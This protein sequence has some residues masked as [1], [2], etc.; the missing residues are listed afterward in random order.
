MG[1]WPRSWSR[2]GNRN[3]THYSLCFLRGHRLDVIITRVE[4][5]V[6]HLFHCKGGQGRVTRC[7]VLRGAFQGTWLVFPNG[8]LSA[9]L[10]LGFKA[11]ISVLSSG[12]F[13]SPITCSGSTL[14]MSQSPK[15]AP[16]GR[17]ILPAELR[18][19]LW[20]TFQNTQSPG[21]PKLTTCSLSPNTLP[22]NL[23]YL[24]Q[25]ASPSGVQARNHLEA[26]Q[27]WFVGV[28]WWIG[29]WALGPDHLGSHPSLAICCGVITELL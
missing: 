25:W 19:H 22:S 4:N 8:H 16:L 12:H 13:H 23:L 21:V 10:R 26:A 2:P 28:A 17:L 7:R 20:V 1:T 9:P 29:R 14:P 5:H 11:E 18:A 6:G 24:I 3:P 27:G 15:T